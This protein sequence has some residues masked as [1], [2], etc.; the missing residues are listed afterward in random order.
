MYLSPYVLEI[1][2]STESLH[3]IIGHCSLEFS[4]NLFFVVIL[5]CLFC[6]LTSYR[7]IE[8]DIDRLESREESASL[9]LE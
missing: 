7:L 5:L 2:D 6:S 4:S 3:L 9:S 8:D 1:F